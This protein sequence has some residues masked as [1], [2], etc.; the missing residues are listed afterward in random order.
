MMTHLDARILSELAVL[1][2][3]D[4]LAVD[5]ETDGTGAFHAKL[6]GM[7]FCGEPGRAYWLPA[8]R[9]EPE[10]L[11]ALLRR[12]QLVFH[13]AKFDLHV[14]ERHGVV[15]D[16]ADVFDTML[17]AHALDENRSASLK[18]LAKEVLGETDVTRFDE[19]TSQLSLFDTTRDLLTY[20][21]ADA[22][23]TFRLFL[24]FRAQLDRL[25]NLARLFRDNEMPLMRVLRR[26]EKHG[27]LLDTAHLSRVADDFRRRLRE[28]EEVIYRFAGRAFLV[29]SPFELAELL[30]DQLG[31]PARRQTRSGHRSVNGFVLE[32]LEGTHPIIAPLREHRELTKLMDA[33]VDKL[34]LLVSP[35]T[36]RVHGNFNQIG[37]VTG[38]I[39]SND[40]NLQNIPKDATIRSAFIAPEGHVLIDADFSQIELRCVA[41]Y[42][43]D[44]RMSDAFER[45]VDLHRKTIADIAGKAVDAVTPEERSLAKAIN[46]GL[47]YGMGA[48]RLASSTGI[49][50]A[51]AEAF[52]AAYF[53]TYSGVKR[54]RDRVNAYAE[55]H[56]QVVNMFGRRRRFGAGSRRTA[57]NGLIQ[58]TAADICRVKMI[59]LDA[60]LPPDNKMLVQ[61]HDEILFEAPQE[62]VDEAVNL[63][64]SI[65]E[66]PVKDAKGR[67]FR[68]PIRVDIGVGRS[69]G[70]AKH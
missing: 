19:V 57:L 58:G 33:Y 9:V 54:F 52:I 35:I 60:M 17:A 23:Y 26:M 10:A 40:P 8:S 7:S 11:T 5:T 56:G 4:T 1:E 68:V 12:K 24:A 22:D 36:G 30:F 66:A 45:D 61:V 51:Q 34:P 38:R 65:M 69:W 48:P 49:T 70:D 50:L 67:P 14:L 28:L 46:F 62:R 20:A 59:A 18:S 2:P 43:E 15:L 27:I 53:E 31:L 55:S 44:P 63:I 25:P 42:S 47:I 6:V 29:S 32:E 21:C 41:H 37:T 16:D 64:R 13:N 3:Y 39:S